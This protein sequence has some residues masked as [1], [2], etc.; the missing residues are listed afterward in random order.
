M[1]LL[2]AMILFAAVLVFIG[3]IQRKRQRENEILRLKKLFGKPSVK[4]MSPER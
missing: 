2:L 3:Q 1:Q 4:K